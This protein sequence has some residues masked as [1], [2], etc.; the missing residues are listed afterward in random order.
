MKI[1]GGHRKYL[2]SGLGPVT[3]FLPRLSELLLCVR[4]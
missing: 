2:S 3:Y 1:L 4:S